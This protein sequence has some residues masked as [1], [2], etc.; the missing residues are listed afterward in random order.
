MSRW[1]REI[2]LHEKTQGGKRFREWWKRMGGFEQ[3]LRE[4]ILG[5]TFRKPCRVHAV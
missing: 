5:R 4:E 1:P 3:L 2:A